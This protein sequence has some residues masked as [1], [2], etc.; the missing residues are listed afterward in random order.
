MPMNQMII[1]IAIGVLY[2]IGFLGKAGDWDMGMFMGQYEHSID[3]KGRTI[4]PAEFREG[5][6]TSFVITRGLDGCAYIYPMAE[7]DIFINKLMT[8]STTHKSNREILRYFLSKSKVLIPDKQGR[9]VMP[10]PI[11]DVAL[12]KEE[13]IFVGLINHIEVWDKTKY[14]GDED[15]HSDGETIASKLESLDFQL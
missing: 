6:G 9:I 15:E 4:V 2:T 14:A 3:A 7:W 10:Q 12:M 11:R 1:Q 5:L 8:L 13:L